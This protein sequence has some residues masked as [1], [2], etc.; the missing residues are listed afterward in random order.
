M[1]VTELRTQSQESINELCMNAAARFVAAVVDGTVETE[2]HIDREI[3]AQ[4]KENKNKRHKS[5][6]TIYLSK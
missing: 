1:N 2:L 6:R 5:T 3:C 4:S